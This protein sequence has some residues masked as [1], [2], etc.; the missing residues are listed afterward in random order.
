MPKSELAIGI[1]QRENS[2]KERGDFPARRKD[3][4]ESKE[5][6]QNEDKN[7]V[8]RRVMRRTI[9]GSSAGRRSK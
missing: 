3:D 8:K 1:C 9:S 5:R 6:R 2:T 4:S 7:I